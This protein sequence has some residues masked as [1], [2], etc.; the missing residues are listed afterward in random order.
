MDAHEIAAQVRT[1][2]LR[3]GLTQQQ[4]ADALGRGLAWVKKF[5]AGDRQ[6]DPRVSLLI[7]R[8]RA[9]DVPLDTL[10]GKDPNSGG[11]Q[12]E[13]ARIGAVRTASRRRARTAGP[14]S[15]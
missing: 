1:W 5:E 4:F 7:E 6:A 11:Q 15:A 2:R 14:P 9:L 13:D 10:L 3:R 12:A 8:A